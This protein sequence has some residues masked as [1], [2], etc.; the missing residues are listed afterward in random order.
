MCAVLWSAQLVIVV[1]MLLSVRSHLKGLETTLLVIRLK[2][3]SLGTWMARL[4]W[5][6]TE[7]KHAMEAH[8]G[9]LCFS[10]CVQNRKLLTQHCPSTSTR[11]SVGT[12]S[13]GPPGEWLSVSDG[14]MMIHSVLLVVLTEE[15][16]Q[17]V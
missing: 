3:R 10:L 12:T 6:T 14:T 15:T 1:K 17:G 13:S 7:E 11:L 5:C 16:S 2:A 4:N 8:C 9:V